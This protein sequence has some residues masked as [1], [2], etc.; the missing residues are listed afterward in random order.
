MD[1]ARQKQ[2]VP[3]PDDVLDI[4]ESRW[5]NPD[6]VGGS[7]RLEALRRCLGRIGGPARELLQ[8]RYRDGLT[9]AVI[10]QKLV[11]STDAVYQTLSRTHRALRTCIERETNTPEAMPTSD[12]P[13]SNASCVSQKSVPRLD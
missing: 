1:M 11:R 6:E 7:D 5:G 3:I 10:A 8:M 2:L 4:L 13:P 12:E 9:V